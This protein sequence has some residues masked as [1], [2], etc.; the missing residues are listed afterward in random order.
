MKT[1]FTLPLVMASAVLLLLAAACKESADTPAAI[2]T[3]AKPS[4]VQEDTIK[5]RL[6]GYSL[7]K[8][9]K[10]YNDNKSLE[11]AYAKQLTIVA[12]DVIEDQS[13]IDSNSY[14]DYTEAFWG[15]NT[16][17]LTANVSKADLL[18]LIGPATDKEFVEL[19]F[20]DK[21]NTRFT[22]AI[23][24]NHSFASMKSCIP[25]LRF[26]KMLRDPLFAKL[27]ITKGLQVDPPGYTGPYLVAILIYTDTNGSVQYFDIVS[28]P[29]IDLSGT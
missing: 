26:R 15:K 14:K 3:K 16:T 13:E 9:M 18:A 4:I 2:E 25:A 21:R 6:S 1:K 17:P 10:I 7:I 24:K 8:L 28:D 22:P 19:S 29:T 11:S 5:K 23:V 20:D 27:E 12:A